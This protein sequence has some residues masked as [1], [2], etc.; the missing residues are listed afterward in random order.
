MRPASLLL[1]TPALYAAGAQN[2]AQQPTHT[3]SLLH[4]AAQAQER[5]DFKLASEDYRKILAQHPDSLEAEIGL[6]TALVAMGDLDGAIEFD[7]RALARSP[8]NTELRTNLGLAYY[9]KGDLNHARYQLEAAHSA[10]PKNLGA[11]LALSYVYNKLGRAADTLALLGPLEKSQQ[12]NLDFEYSLGFAMIQNGNLLEGATRMENVARARKAPDAWFLAANARFGLR[13]FLESLADAEEAL[14]ISSSFPG[15]HT[16]AG[17]SLYAV[18]RIDDAIAQF[19]A[20]LIQNPRDF[21][22]NLYLG[23]MLRFNKQDPAAARPLLEL[24]LSLHPQDPL[25]RFEVAKVRNLQGDVKGAVEMLEGLEK[26]DPNW[27]EPH[28][29]LASLYYKLH[30]IEDSKRERDII[31]K[32]EASGRKEGPPAP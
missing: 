15:A 7:T 29:E 22:A 23:S 4:E 26:T 27:L 14:K 25:A 10:D 30:R 19:R 8:E 24:A 28:V 6:G 12:S 1:L 20:A 3:D 5:G 21:I 2:T 13:N 11:T 32:L 18:G 16:L 31:Q 17:Q 9:R